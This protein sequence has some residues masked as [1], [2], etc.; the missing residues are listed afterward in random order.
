MDRPLTCQELVELVT[1]YLEGSLG[2]AE[3]ARFEAHIAQ[4]PGCATYLDQMRET[5]RIAGR[6]EE[7]HLAE[8]ARTRLL[9]AFRAWKRG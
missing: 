8:P 9:D 7:E 4:C 2:P 6:V 3:R 1:E 5:A